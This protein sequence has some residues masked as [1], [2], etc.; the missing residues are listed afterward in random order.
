ML[1]HHPHQNSAPESPGSTPH[2]SSLVLLNLPQGLCIPHLPGPSRG[3]SW[4][5]PPTPPHLL[6]SF[7]QPPSVPAGQWAAATQMEPRMLPCLG[8][9][10]PQGLRIAP[11]M[12]PPPRAPHL[13]N[14][15]W[16]LMRRGD[17][18]PPHP[19]GPSQLLHHDTQ[20]RLQPSRTLPAPPAWSEAP[21]RLPRTDLCPP[22]K[23]HLSH[24]F[25]PRG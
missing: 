2:L 12:C 22:A 6:M 4:W 23:C 19:S 21:T 8:A 11:P 10:P 17:D 25:N 18:S 15:A 16:E 9:A 1:S 7:T 5:S 14:L 3:V 13:E 24:T 20:P